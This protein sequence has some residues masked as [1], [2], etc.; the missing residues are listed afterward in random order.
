MPCVD[1]NLNPDHSIDAQLIR[2]GIP[3]R[4]DG[5]IM[6]LKTLLYWQNIYL[7]PGV[8]GNGLRNAV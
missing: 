7:M 5:A 2:I 1:S 6:L 8:Q 4:S 3:V